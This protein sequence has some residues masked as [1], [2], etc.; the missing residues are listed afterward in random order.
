MNIKNLKSVL[1][2]HIL[3]STFIGLI[4]IIKCQRV[5]NLISW[6]VINLLSV[7]MCIYFML[8]LFTSYLDY[9][10]VTNIQ[11]IYEQPMEFPAFTLCQ[12]NWNS[13]NFSSILM[14][15][16]I[17]YDNECSTNPEQYFDRYTNYCFTFNSGL[18]M[19]NETIPIFNSTIGG[20]D[21]SIELG[22]FL[23]NEDYVLLVIHDRNIKRYLSFDYNIVDNLFWV[24]NRYYN[25]YK[26]EKRV[27]IKLDEPY[28]NCLKD[29]TQFKFN[30]SLV[31]IYTNSGM[32]YTQVDCLS[33]CFE[34][35]YIESN[36]CNCTTLDLTR[37]W[38]DCFVNQNNKSI[39]ECT[40][41]NRIKFSRTKVLEKCRNYCPLECDTID[42]IVS[43]SIYPYEKYTNYTYIRIYF[44]NLKYTLI[45]QDEKLS[46]NDFIAN[47]GGTVGLFVGL[48]FLSLFEIIDLISEL[49]TL[50]SSKKDKIFSFK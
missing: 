10:V 9:A 5:F 23:T 33:Y 14:S 13:I 34:L 35:H 32:K 8:P 44:R 12:P 28:N 16:S 49:I 19:N 37:I 3:N 47:I 22:I 43:D 7:M 20:Y 38:E 4:K 45:S 26:I 40:F 2:K 46:F 18:N 24:K 17:G 30:K 11:T 39:K 41:K 27:E 21:D 48:N 1:E 25:E 50:L 15:C 29:L 31:D 6:T 42:Y 36:P